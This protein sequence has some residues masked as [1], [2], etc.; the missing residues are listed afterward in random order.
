MHD[1]SA[2]DLCCGWLKFWMAVVQC[3]KAKLHLT[4]VI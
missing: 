3:C 1:L 2:F 4:L